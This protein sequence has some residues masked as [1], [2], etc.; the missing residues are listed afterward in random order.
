MQNARC[1]IIY[2]AECKVQDAKL[3]K[4]QSAK[5]T[6]C[7]QDVSSLREN[8]RGEFRNPP[9]GEYI[10]LYQHFRES[11][12]VSDSLRASSIARRQCKLRTM[13]ELGLGRRKPFRL[14][15]GPTSYSALSERQQPARTRSRYVFLFFYIRA[16]DSDIRT[17][18]A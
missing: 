6:G 10:F 9:H 7:I 12:M 13:L 16:H 8:P 18:S 5:C 2:D 4:M 11:R 17:R 15:D 3:L 1:K 14:S